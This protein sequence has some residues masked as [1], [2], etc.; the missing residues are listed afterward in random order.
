M[1]RRN[2]E[3]L[4]FVLS[5]TKDFLSLEISAKSKILIRGWRG[6]TLQSPDQKFKNRF[7]LVRR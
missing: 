3:E 4:F 2:N 5:D 1:K 7:I 6:G